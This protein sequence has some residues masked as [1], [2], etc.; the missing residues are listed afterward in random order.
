M[1]KRRSQESSPAK[2]SPPDLDPQLLRRVVVEAVEP[3]I[4]GGRFPIKR[5]V[6]E[7]VRV[8]ADVFVDGHDA[9]SAVVRYRRAGDE[10]WREMPM[11]SIGNDRWQ[12]SFTVNSLG[13]YEYTVDAW[14]DRFASWRHELS[15]KVGAGQD[16]S[17]E[18]LEG[19]ALVAGAIGRR[20][21]GASDGHVLETLHTLETGDDNGRRVAAALS[22][23]LAA[24]M[25]ARPDRSQATSFDRVLEVRV[26]R[27]RAR[28]GAWYE[29]FPRSAGSDPSRSATFAEAAAM[30][31]YVASM[32]F[33]VLYLP[34]IHP[35]GRTFRKGPNN[36]LT[37]TPAD[38]GSPWAIGSDEGGHTAIEPG[39][40]TIEDFD[41][42]VAAAAAQRLEI[43]LDVAFQT[44]P[45]HPYVREHPEW[46]R[47]RP[48]G[49]IKYAENPPK[50]YQDIYPLN[51]ESENWQ[52]LWHELKRIF[53]FWMAHGVKMFRVDNPH[54][55]PFRFWEWALA[56][57]TRDH[58]DVILL[59]E[60]FTRPKV[61]KYLAKAG[62][63]QSYTYFTW[64]N[65]RD[66]LVE[67]FTELT[68]T[69]VQE[70]LRPNLFANTP[71]IL[72]AYLQRG[73]RPAFQIRLILAATLGASYGIY[74][75]FEL[76]ENVPLQNG[77]EEYLDS[78]KYQIRVRDYQHADSLAE[79]I[80]R[81]N[82]I[83]R[84]HPALQYDSG[85]AFHRTDNGDLL[86]YSKRSPDGRDLVFVVVN[87]DPANMQHGF[88]Q[89]PLVDWGITPHAIVEVV[90]LL[91][92][93]R[94][95]WRGEWNYVR[96]DPQ[97]RVA[98]VLHVQLPAPLPSPAD[99]A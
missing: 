3:Q 65:S 75:G 62:F 15:K 22:E 12:A 6:G 96:L 45:D 57:L 30:L 55:K 82:A 28:F 2:E 36:S 38:P 32:G 91:S 19:A 54:T 21:A 80:G 10:R 83:R 56:D 92:S 95:F 9:V 31:P 85:L 20:P 42:F 26:D 34:P 40:G 53:E 44:S 88:V 4:D 77:S 98:H 74:S 46:F 59:S 70:Y 24:F 52:S 86:A 68:R 18:L 25:A 93:E 39:L 33:D 58:P 49:T 1:T 41:A 17:S 84:T 78:E 73:G 37:S 47:R 99:H 67:Y 66:E 14:I 8:R 63:T 51:F 87:L 72:H 13:R 50:K 71:D 79:L 11:A 94:Y 81:I 97:D 27:E 76:A 60:A 69:S 43:A 61:M 35:I 5:T 29:I 89:L 48:D 23:E 16:V 90:D 7:Q 64:R